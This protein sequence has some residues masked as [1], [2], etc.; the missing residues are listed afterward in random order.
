[1]S[2]EP[3]LTSSRSPSAFSE[4][5]LTEGEPLLADASVRLAQ[6][7]DVI[8]TIRTLSELAVESF[9]DGCRITLLDEVAQARGDYPFAHVAVTS[10]SADYAALAREIQERYPLAPDAPSG[11]PFVIRTGQS[12]L[13]PPAA[14]AAGALAKLAK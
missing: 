7:L 5:H 10:R 1:M 4:G 13:V 3:R 12:Q 2:S 11:F 6:S 9:A 8:A 14:F